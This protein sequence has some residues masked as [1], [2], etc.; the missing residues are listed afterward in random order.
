MRTQLRLA[1]LAI[2]LASS[3]TCMPLLAGNPAPKV[4]DGPTVDFGKADKNGD[5]SISKDEALHVP[6]LTS[7]FEMLD[8]DMDELV[9]PDEFALWNRARKVEPPR[10]PTTLPSGS[11]GAQHMPKE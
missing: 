6:D 5:G 10:D 7:A 1:T 11:A 2:V 3:G 8:T 4:P 9:S